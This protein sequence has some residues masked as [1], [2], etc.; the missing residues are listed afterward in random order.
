MLSFCVGGGDDEPTWKLR[1][2]ATLC[3]IVVNPFDQL[4][5]L[6]DVVDAPAVIPIQ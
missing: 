3:D 1:L 4:A 5:D 6:D 2:C